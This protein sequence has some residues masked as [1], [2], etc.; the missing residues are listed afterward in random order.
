MPEPLEHRVPVPED[1]R[2]VAPWVSCPHDP[3]HR[4][5]EQSRVPSR[6]ARV[7]R[8]AKAMRLDPRP[9]R[10]CQDHSRHSLLPL[11]S[12]NQNRRYMGDPESQQ[13]PERPRN[14]AGKFDLQIIGTLW[15]SEKNSPILRR[16]YADLAC[17]EVERISV[18]RA[19]VRCA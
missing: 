6:S 16:R 1:L 10:V 8:L 12:L 15:F 18:S 17:P 5:D 7:R 9:L 19:E 11:E 14:P 13:A 3:Q 2:Q 4:L